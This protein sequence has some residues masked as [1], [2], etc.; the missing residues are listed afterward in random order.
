M[1]MMF[2]VT[3]ALAL[4]LVF[5]VLVMTVLPTACDYFA[6]IYRRG[7]MIIVSAVVDAAA[8]LLSLLMSFSF[9]SLLHNHCHSVA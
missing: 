2:S 7:V 6:I 5:V 4:A 3:L 9:S 8:A 1:M